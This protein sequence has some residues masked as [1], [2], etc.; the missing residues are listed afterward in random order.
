MAAI[1]DLTTLTAANLAVD[2]WLVVNDLDA[3]TDKKTAVASV[4]GY[5]TTWTP[6]LA[7]AGSTTGV[8]YTNRW[9]I[10]TTNGLVVTIA[11]LL[12]LSNKGS[13]SAGDASKIFGLPANVRSG[14]AGIVQVQWFSMTS[15]YVT[16]SGLI[17]GTDGSIELYGATA[18]AA[19]LSAVAYSG[20]ANASLLYVAGTYL[21]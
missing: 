8:T 11:A 10:Y 18:A 19:S 5:S 14:Y 4:R 2:D 1:T 21:V 17:S 16:M 13:F 6:S 15:S 12:Y 9:G 20:F 7:F 3:T